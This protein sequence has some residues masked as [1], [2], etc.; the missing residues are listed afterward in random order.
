[1]KKFLSIGLC[2]FSFHVINAQIIDPKIAEKQAFQTKLSETTKTLVINLSSFSLPAISEFKDELSGWQGK[3][4][5][6]NLNEDTRI[7]SILHNQLLE[8]RE[9]DDVLK[10]YLIHKDFIISHN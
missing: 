1:M 8:N 2:V 4:I 3:I 6:I 9:I 5:S 10:K 7:I